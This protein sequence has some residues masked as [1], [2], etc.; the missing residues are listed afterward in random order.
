MEWPALN[1]SLFQKFVSILESV[2][3][4]TGEWVLIETKELPELVV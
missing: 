2:E 3:E 4:S 1:D